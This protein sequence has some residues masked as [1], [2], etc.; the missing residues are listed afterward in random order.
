MDRSQDQ[1]LKIGKMLSTYPW[2]AILLLFL[3]GCIF[4]LIIVNRR[5]K[6]S[7]KERGAGLGLTTSEAAIIKESAA[8]KNSVVMLAGAIAH[9][10]NNILSG[11]VS[12]PELLLMQL[13]EESPLKSPLTVIHQSGQRAAAAVSDLLAITRDISELSSRNNINSLILESL[14]SCEWGL[15]HDKFPQ[16]KVETKLTS[17]KTEALCSPTHVEKSLL[18]LIHFSA[19]SLK[20][21]GTIY[22]TSEVCTLNPRAAKAIDLTTGCYLLVSILNYGA[23]IVEEDLAHLFE[24]FYSE[25]TMGHDGSGILMAVVWNSM[26]DHG[27]AVTVTSND[28]ETC[29]KLYYP[30]CHKE[31]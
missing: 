30:L 10:L 23:K 16:L 4:Y 12:Y 7:V 22:V 9:D 18:N 3:V 25:K 8:R 6:V 21:T 29:F 31:D 28:E 2:L 20:G 13:P 1:V 17:K 14:Q 26:L 27:G 15:L 11:I 24:P 19:E 5:L